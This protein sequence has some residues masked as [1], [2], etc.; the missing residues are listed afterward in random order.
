[1]A[2]TSEIFICVMRRAGERGRR[3]QQEAFRLADTAQ[4]LELL[5]RHI[6]RNWGYIGKRYFVMPTL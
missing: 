1:M 4:A 6:A 3:D 2:Q 5:W